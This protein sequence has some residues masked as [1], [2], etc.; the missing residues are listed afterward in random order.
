[1]VANMDTTG[2]FETYYALKDYHVITC[3]HKHYN[4]EDFPEDLDP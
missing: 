1:M 3:L 2:T 4:L